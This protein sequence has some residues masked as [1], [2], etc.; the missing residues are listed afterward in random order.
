MTSRHSPGIV[1]LAAGLVVPLVCAGRLGADPPKVQQLRIQ[2]V[3][4]TTYFHVRLENPADLAPWNDNMLDGRFRFM[5]GT[6]LD[7]LLTPRLA[8]QSDAAKAV[9]RSWRA[10]ELQRQFD[11]PGRPTPDF[12]N[13]KFEDKKGDDKDEKRGEE[14]K[15]ERGA[16]RPGAAA[17]T[18]E[19]VGKAIGKNK[20]AFVLLYPKESEEQRQQEGKER[21]KAPSL[22]ELLAQKQRWAEVPIELDF[23][24]AKELP[25][26]AG[27]SVVRD[28]KRGPGNDDLEGLWAA[29]QA[30]HFALLEA[31][32]PEFGFYGQ[33]AESTSRKYQVPQIGGGGPFFGPRD[34]RGDFRGGPGQGSRR[35]YEVTTGAAAITETLALDRLRGGVVRDRAEDR[36]VP[37]A[38]LQ[39]ID[40][41]E[42]PWQ[43]MMAG[44]K[45][46]DEPLARLVPHDN[47]YIHF[48]NIAKFLEAGDLL[49]QWGTTLVRAYEVNSK[50]YRLKQRYEQQ[51]CLKSTGLARIFGPAVI[52]G[53]AVTGNDPYIREGSDLTILFHLANP[54]LFKAAVEP[55]IKEA[56]Q[57]FRAKLKEE[58]ADYQNV[59]IESYVT[60]LR[61]VSLHR[62][63][64]GDVAVYSNSPAGIRRVIDVSGD[65]LKPLADSLDFQYMRT[66]FRADDKDADGF[67]FLSDPFIRNLVGPALRIKE[68]RRLEALT[69]LQMA[70]HA[71]MFTAWETDKLPV[72]HEH[73]LQAAGL[74][75]EEL[76][77]PDGGG[78]FWDPEN[79]VAVSGIYNTV[80]FATPLVELPIDFVSPVEAREYEDFRLQYLGLWRRYFDPIGMRLALKKDEVRWETYILPL[81]KNTQYNELRRITG[82]IGLKFDPAVFSD[83]TLAQ[84]LVHLSPEMFNAPGRWLG[85][86]G[87]LDDWMIDVGLRS[88]LGEW[89]TIRLDDSAIYAKLLES[90]IRRELNPGE[91]HDFLDD[92]ELALQVPLTL[93][94]EIRNPMVFAG[95]LASLRR[96]VHEALPGGIEWQPMVPPYK[97]T[98]IVRVKSRPQAEDRGLIAGPN[99]GR[100]PNFALYYAL[101]DGGF[102]I[103]LREEPIKDLID[104][105][106]A[107][108]EKGEKGRP[109]IEAAASLHLAPGA[110]VQARDL[111]SLY[112]EWEAHR[113]AQQNNRLLYALFH[114]H[115]ASA[116][117]SS[118]TV[119][120][121][122]LQ[123]LGYVPVSPDLA[124]FGYDPKYDEVSNQRQGTL[125]TPKLNPA[126]DAA[127]PAGQLLQQLT[128]IRAD[129]RFRE[130]G[131]HTTVTLR[132]TGKK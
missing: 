10:E 117:D 35:L 27:G 30:T 16:E 114:S 52:K 79:K 58:K 21:K 31:Q 41:A 65:K 85:F 95:I 92:I 53:V 126:V 83:K 33:A 71:A 38:R 42:H 100:I 25:T 51:L 122:A 89:A 102:Y 76:F 119:E 46:A 24:R 13:K 101:V 125:R 112:L 121:A 128:S 130:D 109:Q 120:A 43:T 129:L 8:P 50:D 11:F 67:V 57:K 54:K 96:A 87:G 73:L 22:A 93:G 97:G 68:R 98:S 5:G 111:L 34:F 59:T 48:K 3:G 90:A 44:K 108:K 7:P 32:T 88:W 66:V 82:S 118:E 84:L 28:A 116:A 39:G 37:I 20:V 2:K 74:K 6:Q 49:D 81:V 86:G 107:L 61:E 91:R 124:P 77:T 14:K 72:N 70:M 131:V 9:Y 56:R 36:T 55:F 110:A 115:V 15:G 63:F 127:S 18:M 1:L 29:A 75:Q 99:A 4:D 78:A 60:P 64:L 103:S 40:I 26:P 94:V 69:S 132:K 47:Y 80:H 17:N 19:F 123:Y 105:S 113:R 12:E 106:V 62:A 45:P 23:S 104:R